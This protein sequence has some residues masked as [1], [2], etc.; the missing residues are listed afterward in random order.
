VTSRD[1]ID[2]REVIFI[3]ECC[4]LDYEE[5]PEDVRE[6]ADQAID[7]LQN[8]RALPVKMLRSLRGALAGITEVRLAYDDANYRVYVSLKCPWIVMVLDAG[9]KK[10]TEGA[11]IPRWQRERLEARHKR[12]REYCT[13]HDR[14]LKAE[15]E[16]RRQRREKTR[17]KEHSQ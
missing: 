16:K 10:S 7:A 8:S 9:I 14:V 11:N 6:G 2:V 1:G 4:R 3:N 13:A 5:M 15:Y 17:A 12:A